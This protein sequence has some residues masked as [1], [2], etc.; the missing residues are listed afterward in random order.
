MSRQT[1]PMVKITLLTTVL[2]L[3]TGFAP[4]L[5]VSAQTEDY[6]FDIIQVDGQVTDDVVN[7]N[8]TGHL[9]A[10]NEVNTTIELIGPPSNLGINSIRFDGKDAQVY[11]SD[12]CYYIDVHLTKGNHT[13][14]MKFESSLKRYGQRELTYRLF[15][16]ALKY[17]FKVDIPK[18]V[19]T[20]INV[21]TTQGANVEDLGN[22]VEV[23]W[24][25]Y[26]IRDKTV[27]LAWDSPVKVSS[28][29]LWTEAMAAAVVTTTGLELQ[30]LYEQ[31]FPDRVMDELQFTIDA[32]TEFVRVSQGFNWDVSSSTLTPITPLTGY[33][34]FTVD[35]KLAGPSTKVSVP[36]P[37]IGMFHGTLA[38]IQRGDVEAKITHITDATPVDPPT[39]NLPK[40]SLVLGAYSITS[41]S[42]V[43]VE[44]TKI[45]LEWKAS[46]L[47]WAKVGPK[48]TVI[49]ELLVLEIA[50]QEVRSISMVVPAGFTI[51]SVSGVD[52]WRN[53]DGTLEIRFTYGLLGEKRIEVLATA[54]TMN[55]SLA[56]MLP[57]EGF[58][59]D[60]YFAVSSEPQ[61]KV[62]SSVTSA[63]RITQDEVPGD[64]QGGINVP[65]IL[66]IYKGDRG[67]TMSIAYDLRVVQETQTTV[68]DYA[69]YT[70]IMTRDGKLMARATYVVKN[71]RQE[72]LRVVM[73]NGTLIWYV[74]VAGRVT[75]IITEGN[76]LVI[77][78]IR[79]TTSGKNIPFIVEVMYVV[80]EPSEE[81]WFMFPSVD[82]PVVSVDVNVGIPK[83]HRIADPQ[84]D[85]PDYD[86]L[87]S[88]AWTIV[89]PTIDNTASK[90]A[91]M[92]AG[93]YGA[94]FQSGFFKI[95]NT[96]TENDQ[97]VTPDTRHGTVNLL[98]GQSTK[99]VDTKDL[100]VYMADSKNNFDM[101]TPPSI[102]GSGGNYSLDLSPG[103]YLFE[104]GN[105][106]RYVQV[107]PGGTQQVVLSL[108]DGQ[109]DLQMPP[110]TVDIPK[111]GRLLKFR[112]IFISPQDNLQ[113]K[114]KEKEPGSVV[115]PQSVCFAFSVSVALIVGT[116]AWVRRR[117]RARAERRMRIKERKV[118][119]E[120]K[121][122]EAIE[123]ERK[124]DGGEAGRE[125]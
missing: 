30:V 89:L 73:P 49:D 29:D 85:N 76:A 95:S 70:L 25:L 56:P 122:T 18:K 107:L 74:L 34:S 45:L 99:A 82:V 115:S 12:V 52:E 116:I 120:K 112:R 125:P 31:D 81:L 110:T 104:Y 75:E 119:K 114:L 21:T 33:A 3:M 108:S 19:G 37:S 10:E 41:G 2:V 61:V 17:L 72:E 32:G 62:T 68:I 84:K 5:E 6:I 91:A 71:M 48:Q 118:K 55:R 64:F 83:N 47:L 46:I 24:R 66:Q 103:Q 92:S 44:R 11:F 7:F 80:P 87:G 26:A 40:G 78:L 86:Y 54:P 36:R 124:D 65:D 51:T 123:T 14:E 39:L 50:Y 22:M 93:G 121:A 109:M 53:S 106:T 111:T 102:I 1:N 100:Q 15:G 90:P 27:S 69:Q 13:I 20:E 38:V 58:A 42:A 63:S 57:D 101:I 96:Q 88:Y 67:S 23:S 16:A 105:S 79:S 97:Y 98:S 113:I 35:F 117:G 77:P 59:V 8:Y 43:T 28:V 4:A 94:P 9:K 60:V